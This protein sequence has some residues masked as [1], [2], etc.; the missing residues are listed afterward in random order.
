MRSGLA[1]LHG[2]TD[3]DIDWML[4]CGLEQE[5]A[6]GGLVVAE[7]T[8]PDAIFLVA[9]GMLSVF[10]GSDGEGRVAVLGPGQIVGEM[11]FLED[12]PS[13]ATVAA[14]EYSS[15]ICLPA[16]LL[17][18][19]LD[20]DPGFAAR[21]YRSIARLTSQRLRELL[22][23]FGRWTQEAPPAALAANE[24]SQELAAAT[25][26]CKEKLIAA[27][28]A[29]D[30]VEAAREL[31]EALGEFAALLNRIVGPDSP[32]SLDLREELGARVQQELLPFFLKSHIAERLY[33]KPRG[34]ALD[35]QTMEMI[36][37]DP[38]AADSALDAALCQM[39]S[40][41][42]LRNRERLLGEMI[43]HL[44]RSLVEGPF[45]FTTIA[46]LAGR[47][48]FTAL[49]RATDP[50]QLQV[51]V[52]DFDTK[53]LNQ[54]AQRS[55]VAGRAAQFACVKTHLLA[56]V[57]GRIQAGRRD[58]HLVCSAGL[59]DMLEDRFLLR[60]IN[61]AYELL[62]PGGRLILGFYHSGQP[63]RSFLSYILNVDLIHRTEGEVNDLLNRSSFGR[64]AT[65]VRFEAE[66]ACF[67][68]ECVKPGPPL[69]GGSF[70]LRPPQRRA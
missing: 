67:L 9:S 2:L 43:I 34:Y 27:E 42:A 33:H 21:L 66:H 69:G 12:R 23:V 32:V 45:R 53:S 19:K 52:Y 59:A 61:S 7:G 4:D 64:P 50:E 38:G 54:V 11:S 3:A 26:Q 25:Q 14:L 70:G 44:A 56:L 40:L 31:S 5:I 6:P 55:A 51:T 39:P 16:T 10:L 24:A 41:A 8:R 1:V 13:S 58:Q 57:A 62:A 68:A 20:E 37:D 28:R 35:F 17:R 48:A 46:D 36:A 65:T 30:P 15:V 29:E 63:D 22:G 18:P 47:T 49:S 60:V